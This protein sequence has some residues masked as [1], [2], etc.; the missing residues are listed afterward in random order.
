MIDD[1]EDGFFVALEEARYMDVEVGRVASLIGEGQ[2]G[3][4]LCLL[5]HPQRLLPLHLF[6]EINDVALAIRNVCISLIGVEL[7]TESVRNGYRLP[8]A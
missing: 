1:A 3:G 2:I 6:V 4:T 7:P 8:I 5:V